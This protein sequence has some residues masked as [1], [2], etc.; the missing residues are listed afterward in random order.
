MRLPRCPRS[1]LGADRDRHERAQLQPLGAHA[2][3]VQPVAQRAADDGEH[4]VVDRAAERVLDGLEVGKLVAHARGSGGAGRSRRSAASRA[5]GSGPPTRPRP[6]PRRRRAPSAAPRP[7]RVRHRRGAPPPCA[8]RCAPGP[9]CPTASSSAPD[10]SGAG[11]HGSSG[12]GTS[13]G[14]GPRSKITWRDVDARDAVDERVVGLGDEREAAVREA[15]DH[16]HLPQRLGAVELLGE[17][18]PGQQQQLLLGARV[19]QRGLAHVVLEVEA[20]VVDPQRPAG[21]GRRHRQLLAV[22][23]HEVQAPAQRVQDLGRTAAA[24]PRRASARR[25]ACATSAPPGAGTTRRSRSA[26]R[27]APETWVQAIASRVAWTLVRGS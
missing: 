8:G 6:G 17:D 4:D 15:L 26:G 23:R 27:D 24:A 13:V 22:A 18:P 11:C 12:C 7:G 21:P 9:A 25:R 5:P 20:R 1:S 14:T 19:R 16:P 10:G 3:R 2:A